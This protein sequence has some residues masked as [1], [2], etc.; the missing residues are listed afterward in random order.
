MP[1]NPASYRVVRKKS[2]L[3]N[4]AADNQKQDD[5]LQFV[6]EKT[7]DLDTL[8]G[9]NHGLRRHD[10]QS[11]AYE[12]KDF[13]QEIWNIPQAYR[14]IYQPQQTPLDERAVNHG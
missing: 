11:T 14:S 1:E 9:N 5:S 4:K 12:L 2:Y 3:F 10:Q 7:D 13:D 6:I 8:F